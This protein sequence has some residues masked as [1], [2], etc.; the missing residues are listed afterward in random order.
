MVTQQGDITME[1][2]NTLQE[3]FDRGRHE[4][5][6][7]DFD[8]SIESLSQAIASEPNHKL[9]LITRGSAFLKTERYADAVSDFSRAIEIDPEYARAYHLK[10]VAREYIGDN[11]GALDDFS[12]PSAS[13]RSTARH[14]TAVQHC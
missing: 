9:A 3:S 8:S 11:D 14:I 10:G 2:K 7:G 5:I 6:N 1:E 13:N 4:L 12:M